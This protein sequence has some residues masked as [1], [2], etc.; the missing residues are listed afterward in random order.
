MKKL[1]T[2]AALALACGVTACGTTHAA[3]TTD[4]TSNACVT[5]ADAQNNY[6][7]LAD[8]QGYLTTFTNGQVLVADEIDTSLIQSMLKAGC[9][10]HIRFF[11]ISTDS[12]AN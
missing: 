7:M 12:W 2:V 3:T 9:P 11:D 4:T 5:A 10:D 8:Q 6:A 1:I